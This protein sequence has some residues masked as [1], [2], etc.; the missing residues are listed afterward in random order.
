MLNYE[1]FKT[2]IVEHIKDYLPLAY[3][4]AEV[5]IQKIRKNNNQQW[6]SLQVV[7]PGRHVVPSIYLKKMFERYENGMPVKD[8]FR[9]CAS[10]IMD[11]KE[12]E[13]FDAGNMVYNWELAKEHLLIQVVNAQS[14]QEMLT[15]IPYVMKEDLALTYRIMLSGNEDTGASIL[16]DNIMLEAWGVSKE[17]LYESAMENSKV[18]A[19]ERVMCMED[20]LKNMMKYVPDDV[21]PEGIELNESD[22]D[23]MF[24]ITNKQQFY[25]ASAVFYGNSLEELAKKMKSDLYILPSSIHE[26]L[27]V[28][29][30]DHDASELADIVQTVNANVVTKEEQLSD[31]VYHYDPVSKEIK[32]ADTTMERIRE[33]MEVAEN[34]ETYQAANDSPI[35]RRSR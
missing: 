10:V 3:E 8:I 15:Q 6:D 14:N 33:E 32:L 19:P 28:S 16:V 22:N 26:M 34:H 30:K 18:M 5:R 29:A 13:F 27:V 17:E 9:A 21:S 20:M 1:E 11:N 7:M 23:F 2:Y 24:V 4:P 31:H 35:N 25:G 12:D